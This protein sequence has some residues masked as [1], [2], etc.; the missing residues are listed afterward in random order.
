MKNLLVFGKQNAGT[1]PEVEW[2]TKKK[3]KKRKH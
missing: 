3:K 1:R 2:F